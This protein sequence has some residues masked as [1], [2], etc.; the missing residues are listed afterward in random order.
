MNLKAQKPYVNWEN[1]RTY[2][3]FQLHGKYNL[4]KLS[5]LHWFRSSD[6]NLCI[7]SALQSY[8]K[9]KRNKCLLCLV[10]SARNLQLG[11]VPL[12]HELVKT[13]SLEC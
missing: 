5:G 2:Q 13:F 11:H 6:S 9:I 8:I 4:R 10:A 1:E 7:P 12:M 3:S